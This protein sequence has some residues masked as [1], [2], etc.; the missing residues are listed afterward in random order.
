MVG[1]M[2]YSAVCGLFRSTYPGYHI[3]RPVLAILR[4]V[5]A[6]YPE[7]TLIWLVGVLFETFEVGLCVV[8]LYEF[9]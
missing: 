4:I 8:P 1:F 3:V 6:V 9:G 2:S 7:Q 5:V